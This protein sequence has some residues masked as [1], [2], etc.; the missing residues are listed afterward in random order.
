MKFCTNCGTQLEDN[1]NFCT[2]CGAALS[3]PQQQAQSQ[4]TYAQPQYG[5][6]MYAQPAKE[7]GL[8]TAAKIFMIISTVVTGIYILPLAWCLPM[9][10]SYFKKLKTGQPVSTGFKVCTLLF[11]NTIA[12]ILMLCDKDN[13][14]YLI[15]LGARVYA[16][17]E[18]L[19][20]NL[21]EEAEFVE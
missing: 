6:P 14:E 1:V 3:Q 17:T 8:A 4:Q 13:D 12:G 5:Q 19:I 10:L 9:T 16:L 20:C 7:S 21:I 15:S 2:S 18:N 11:V